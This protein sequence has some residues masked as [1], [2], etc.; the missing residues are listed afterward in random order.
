MAKVAA[1]LVAVQPGEGELVNLGGLGVHFKIGGADTAGSIAVVEHPVEARRLVRPHTHTKEDEL[2][3]VLE[4]TIGARVGDAIAQ[5]DA[6][7]Y[8]FKPRGV[9]HTF[10]NPTD[11]P[12]RLLEMIVPAGFEEYFAAMA[13]FVGSGGKPGSPEHQAL[14]APYGVEFSG[15]WIAELKS[16]YGLKLLGEP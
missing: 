11:K 15:D 7:S 10:W 4:G 8:I 6:G 16:R 14:S 13:R 9:R 1:R 5:L 12:A 3:Y 2:S